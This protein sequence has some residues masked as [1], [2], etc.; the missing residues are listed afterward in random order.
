[1]KLTE[2]ILNATCNVLYVTYLSSGRNV[3]SI[4]EDVKC[5]RTTRRNYYRDVKGD[6]IKYDIVLYFGYDAELNDNCEI[7]IDSKIRKIA[8]LK[9]VR[10]AKD[11]IHHYE[12]TL[13]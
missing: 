3:D 9:I 11:N 10:N 4:I 6:H 1:M 13:I 8:S 2:S 12:V 5:R 7:E